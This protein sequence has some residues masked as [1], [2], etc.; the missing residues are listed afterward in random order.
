MMSRSLLPVPFLGFC[1]LAPPSAHSADPAVNPGPT[2]RS[3]HTVV[4]LLS[5]TRSVQPGHP[6]T[7]G[8]RLE[9]EP[10]WH[11]YWKNPGDAGLATRLTWRLPEGFEPGPLQFPTPELL[12]AGP[13]M[14]FGHSGTAVLLV[15]VKTPPSLVPGTPMVLGTRAD[16][17]ECKEAC[18]P[19]KA[20][21]ALTLPVTAEAPVVDPSATAVFAEAR[22]HLPGDGRSWQAEMLVAPDALALLFRPPNGV[23]SRATFFP[24]EKG[25]IEPS[26]AQTLRQSDGIFRLDLVPAVRGAS[27]GPGAA[28]TPPEPAATISGV[29]S[30]ETQSGATAVELVARVV[31][32][33]AIPPASAPGSNAASAPAGGPGLLVALAFAFGGGILLNLMPCVLP[34]LSL[35]VLSFVRHA[36]LHP[37]KAWHQGAAFTAGVLV[38]FWALAGALL[39]LR[40][41]G[42]GVGWGFQ[43]QSPGFVVALAVLF[44][45]LGLNLFGVFEMGESLTTAGNL[46]LG[47]SGLQSSF[48]GGALAT[49][50]A[51]PC[52]APFMGSALGWGLSQPA[53]I[54]LL[55]FTALGLGMA[56]P[57]LFL[58][59][60]PKL[61]RFVPRPGR[62][63]ETFKQLMG[64]FLM[65]TVVFL[66]WLLG[67]QAG[68]DG[69][70]MLLAGLVVVGMGAWSYGRGDT[71]GSTTRSR[72]VA[73]GLGFAL[74]GIGLAVALSGARVA[75]PASP[76][77]A[78]GAGGLVWESWSEER[79][80]ALRA[81]GRAVFV[82]F[83]AAWCLTCQ[84]NE[85]VSLGNAEV[86]AKLTRENVALLRADWTLRDERITRA[87]A[88]HGRQGVP[89]YVLYGR[90][91]L[92][93]PRLLP[94][95][96][97]PGMVLAALDE[98]L[99]ASIRPDPSRDARDRGRGGQ[100]P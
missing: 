1:L 72:R 95:V 48:W 12:P 10:E 69:V 58:S 33:A 76:S 71:H 83:T 64:F 19:G 18:I 81:E 24:L 90:D 30:V 75:P 77:G 15:E 17:L 34:V 47:T 14:S 38:S 3:R 53:A 96:I 67:Q 98:A 35:K 86:V 16:W 84:V 56:A 59:F 52:T 55:V 85:R 97:T 74:G 70:A 2:G 80:A 39:V 32:A 42:Q 79:V 43:L 41:A 26:G 20:E 73:R 54:S 78:K 89:V 66:A 40:A 62:W 94:E 31:K 99:G 68:N 25:I 44:F 46:A 5:E 61:I 82:D 13:L 9:M 92:A 51:T 7:L 37:S 91:P 23:S 11:T 21:L 8:L 60:Q 27:P 29:L 63:M 36:G 22:K 28:S 49:V 87:L 100:A 88:S 57:Y 65:A 93:P 4:T 6:L 50:V 45:V